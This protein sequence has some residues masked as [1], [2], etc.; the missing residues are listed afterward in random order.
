[1]AYSKPDSSSPFYIR[2]AAVLFSLIAL[3]YI[4][5]VGKSVLSPLVFGMLFA[6]LLLP[7]A[8]F[9]ERKLHFARSAAS[10]ASVVLLVL[11]LAGILYLVGS[12]IS[13]LSEDWPL[14]K[15]QVLSALNDLQHWISVKFHVKIRQQMNYLGDAATHFLSTGPSVIGSAVVSVSGQIV[16]LAFTMIYTFFML[17]YRRLITKFLVAVFKDENAVTV[18]DILA[19]MQDSMRNYILGLILEMLIVAGAS[20]LVLWLLGVKYALLLGLITGLFNVIPY[21]GFL[22]ALVLSTLVTFATGAAA[23]KILLVVVSLL[24]VHIVDAN[25]LFPMIVGSKV[26]INALITILGVIIGGNIWGIAG[27]FLAIPVIAVTKIIFD[28]I[29][30]LK[31]WGMLMGHEKDEEQPAP[32]RA[33]IKAEEKA[34]TLGVDNNDTDSAAGSGQY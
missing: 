25:V 8:S 18:Y 31:P 6:M 20:S 32:L 33:E 19:R 30:D 15:Q 34:G 10:G 22:T 4:A 1:M 26:R 24:G 2:L 9:L 29:D 11:F 7:L 5:I 23:G 21:I 13:S 27:M 12:Q 14:F 3:F 28:R 16:F 17:Y